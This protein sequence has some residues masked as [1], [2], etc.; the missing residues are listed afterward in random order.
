MRWLEDDLNFEAYMHASESKTKV[1]QAIDFAEEAIN[2]LFTP[3]EESGA[4]LPWAK[5]AELL[6]FREG[7]VTLWTGINGH[8]KS[9]VMGQAATGFL[10]QGES[11]CIAS[12]EMAPKRTLAR[13]I[14][15]AE[16]ADNGVTPDFAV[17]FVGWTGDK[18]WLYD[19][20]GSVKADKI[21]A[22]MRYCGEE[23]KIKHFFLD[24]LMKC[25]ISQD[26]LDPQAEFVDQICVI[27]KETGMHVHLVAHSRKQRDESGVPGKMDI[28]GSG[29]IADQVFNILTVWRN[30]PKE[31]NPDDMRDEPDALIICDKQRN[32]DWEG[33]ISLWYHKPS[34]QYLADPFARPHNLMMR[35][36]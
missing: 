25:G 5:T 36:P 21:L 33:R 32:G 13:M 7:E 2:V 19:H 35:L 24:S 8:G 14:T 12:L 20:V 15:Q 16:G 3:Q 18:L 1:R 9:L 30:K 22:V 31:E 17:Q 34:M 10:H 29:A 6:R 26:K 11:V 4:R 28:K 23:L 27:A